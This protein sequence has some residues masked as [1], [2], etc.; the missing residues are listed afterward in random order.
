MS[1]K[2]SL[3]TSTTL[4]LMVKQEPHNQMAWA[5]FV[6]RYSHLIFRWCRAWGLQEAEA[7]DVTQ[8]VLLE[9]ARQMRTFTYDPSGSFRA[10]LRVIAY[11]CW[12]RFVKG[13]AGRPRT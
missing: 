2:A 10:W 11:R 9:L 13:R 4:L 6:D 1:G 5:E 3:E 12:C 7:E 8:D